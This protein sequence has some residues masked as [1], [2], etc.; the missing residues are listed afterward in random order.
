[1]SLV[2][3]AQYAGRRISC[4]Q[5]GMIIGSDAGWDTVKRLFK[6]LATGFSARLRVV[7]MAILAALAIKLVTYANS[8]PITSSDGSAGAARIA[9]DQQVP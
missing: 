6:T 4:G 9:L 5:T 3:F 7:F 2:C 8:A 1:M